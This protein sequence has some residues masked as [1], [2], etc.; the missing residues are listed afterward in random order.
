MVVP[1]S[2]QELVGEQ[3]TALDFED[4]AV[5]ET[6]LSVIEQE[7]NTTTD[8]ESIGYPFKRFG[9]AIADFFTFDPDAKMRFRMQLARERLAEANLMAARNRLQR[10]AELIKEY[11]DSLGDVQSRLEERIKI[12]ADVSQIAR[13]AEI[14]AAKSTLILQLVAGKVPEQA[15]DAI[16]RAINN[17]L[18][19][20]ARVRAVIEVVKE[21]NLTDG[22]IKEKVEAKLRARLPTELEKHA[23]RVKSL[24]EK[25]AER[26]EREL[27]HLEQQIEEA[28]E[29]N[30][31]EQAETLEK[32][33]ERLEEG[34]ERRAEVLSRMRERITARI[35][36]VPEKAPEL[37]AET[38]TEEETEV[39]MNETVEESEEQVEAELNETES[40]ETVVWIEVKANETNQSGQGR[41]GQGQ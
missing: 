2:A 38:E 9:E 1:A 33:K 17:S 32:I 34:A 7:Y 25:L 19:K 23:Q 6:E 40:E 36:A 35:R 15:H 37:E 10:A 11:E 24:E 28:L 18:E 22:E 31:T 13:E 26:L 27:A 21:K 16:A 39:E 29:A 30:K 20:K 14:A 8:P 3:T 12:G 4:E 41:G 5:T